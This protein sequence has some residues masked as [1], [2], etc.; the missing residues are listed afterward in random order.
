MAHQFVLRKRTLGFYF[1][2]LTKDGYVRAEDFE[3][4]GKAVV[5]Q[6]ELEEGSE[7]ANKIVESF[8]GFWNAFGGSADVDGNGYITIDEFLAS[9][10]QFTSMPNAKDIVVELNQSLFDAVDTNGS[11]TISLKEY[12]TFIT[13]SGISAEA[14]AAAF[15][16]LDRDGSGVISRAE[17][18]ENA[19]DYWNSEDPTAA[20]NWF[21]ANH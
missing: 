12:T 17:F 21:Y 7:G 4:Y 13:P 16:K 8:I 14:A 10:A 6:F 20:G 1:W 18:G 2:D 15:A 3:A 9:Y 5:A 11:G 19:W